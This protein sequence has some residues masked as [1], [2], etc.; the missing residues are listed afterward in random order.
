VSPEVVVLAALVV[1]VKFLE[2]RQEPTQHYCEA[3]GRGRWTNEQL[4]VT[5]RCIV[6]S[7]DYRIMP[8]CNEELLIDAQVDMQLAARQRPPP[9]TAESRRRPSRSAGLNGD[10]G[11]G[12]VPRHQHPLHRKGKSTNDA[13]LGL[14]LQQQPTPNSEDVEMDLDADESICGLRKRIRAAFEEGCASTASRAPGFPAAAG[15]LDPTVA[16]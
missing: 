9:Q 5:E 13:V 7:L 15:G 3:W 12:S 10:G 8:L 1:A 16:S 11:N 6:E 14:G 4:N 2:D